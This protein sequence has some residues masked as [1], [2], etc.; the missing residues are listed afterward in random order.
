MERNNF[1]SGEELNAGRREKAFNTEP[2]PF[3]R[4]QYMEHAK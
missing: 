4:I 1:D 3:E 2:C